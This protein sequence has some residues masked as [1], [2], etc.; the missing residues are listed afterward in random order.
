MISEKLVYGIWQSPIACDLLTD[1]GE[2]FRKIYAGRAISGPGCDF[3]DAIFT[4]GGHLILGD[5]EIHV[6]AREWY[7]H[8]HHRDSRYNNVALHV[9]MWHSGAMPTVLENGRTIPTVSLRTFL[10]K[11]TGAGHIDEKC[12]SAVYAR[13]CPVLRDGGDHSGLLRLLEQCGGKRF[14][15]KAAYFKSAIAEN[16]PSQILYRGIMGA[17]GYSRNSS[18]FEKLA[19]TLP[20]EVL[21]Q[22]AAGGKYELCALMLG[23]AGLLENRS[24]R[25]VPKIDGGF[26]NEILRIWK[27]RMWKSTMEPGDWCLYGIRPGNSP[28]HRIEAAAELVLRY[29]DSGL[30]E[31][32]V[33]LVRT[34]PG[35]RYHAYLED[36]LLVEK[37]GEP[38]KK[39]KPALLGR[40]RADEITINILLPF[41]YA[42]ALSINNRRLA[43]KARRLYQGYPATGQNYITRLMCRNLEI[44]SGIRLN[45]CSQQ[46]LLYVF[47]THCRYRDCGNCPLGRIGR[48]L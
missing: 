18:A 15:A 32:F 33:E 29:M 14:M 28:E 47:K 7:L 27:E 25:G 19:D 45:A 42:Y 21:V 44:P 16:S 22:A 2:H 37:M 48:Q 30:L 26:Y 39:R 38:G 35:Q 9:V 43:G 1:K 46:G 13:T 12:E 34:A 11:T 6:D 24:G 5:V 3:Q 31:G 17:L 4:I 23:T 36:A 41:V 8:G 20:L 10:D 40:A